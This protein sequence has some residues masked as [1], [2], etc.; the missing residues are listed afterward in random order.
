MNRQADELENE[1]KRLLDQQ[2][3]EMKTLE[4][5]FLD[6][7]QDL[8]RSTSTI[9]SVNIR[10]THMHHTCTHTHSSNK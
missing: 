9:E 5:G 2:K 6:A 7:R 3:H 8:K 4:M 10:L 1:L